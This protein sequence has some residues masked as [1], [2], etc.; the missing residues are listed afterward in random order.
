MHRG[1]GQIGQSARESTLPSIIDVFPSLAVGEDGAIRADAPKDAEV[2]GQLVMV[3]DVQFLLQ[4]YLETRYRFSNSGDSGRQ[5]NK[6]MLSELDCHRHP[7]TSVPVPYYLNCASQSRLFLLVFFPPA[8]L[9]R[10][11]HIHIHIHI[12]Y[13]RRS[14]SL[15]LFLPFFILSS[16]SH[17]F[18]KVAAG[19]GAMATT[20]PTVA[21]PDVEPKP[22][23]KSAA[24][25]YPFWFGGS[26]ASMAA[27][28]THPLDLGKFEILPGTCLP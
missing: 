6:H 18:V 23:A 28:V 17:S 26:A 9:C 19:N 1:R 16:F 22:K 21:K 5:D 3:V 8:I 27:V 4:G 7:L 2:E 25:R 14:L 10:L 12:R 15:P 11:I 24:V 20:A 13:I